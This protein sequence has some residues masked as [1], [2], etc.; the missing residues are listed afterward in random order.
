MFKN[1]IKI[2]IRNLS[3]HKA[4]AG[5]NIFGLAFGLAAFWMIVL[6]IADELSYDR[7]NVNAD[8]IVRVIQHA[9]WG[10]N[11]MHEAPTS[12][13]FAPAMK[14]AFP[15]V[16]EATRILTEGGG[17]INYKDKRLTTDDIF[18]TDSNIFQVFTF[19]FLYGDA[20]TALTAPQSMVITE[21]LAVKLFGDPQKALNETIYFENNYPN[22]TTG[23]IKN[24]PQN[25]HFRF[26]ALRS[27]PQG[28]SGAWQ[29]FDVYTYLL[30]KKG[31][32]IKSLEAKL[33]NFAANS[34]QKL[35]KVDDYKM[36]LQPLT[37]IH[38]HSDLRFEIS[39]NGS[40]N[41]VYLF[42]AIATLI[43][44]IAIINYINLSTA[45]S[46]MRLKE[47]G[48]RKVVGSGK[49]QL[50]AMFITESVLV[51]LLAA[52]IGILMMQI[53]MPLF[54]QL[55][56]K[57]LVIWQFGK[58][59]TLILLAGFT[60]LTG[61]ISGI[62][63]SLFLSRFKTIP[64]LKGQMGNLSAN[65][66]F[67]RSL[68]IFQFVITVVMI[69]ASLV[70]YR[71]LQFARHKDLGFN[72]DQL[73]TFHIDDRKVRNNTSALK[74][75]LLQN[76]VIEGVA[77]AG[78][79]IGN[80][81]LGGL[82]YKLQSESGDF[83]TST[84]MAQELMVDADYVPAMEIKILNGRNFST[85]MPSDQYGS[86]L[87]NETLVKKSGWKNP[88]GK[89]LRFPIDDSTGFG[90]RTVV[91]VVKDFHTYSL[92]HLVEPLVMVMPPVASM[93]DNLYVKIARGRVKEA[94]GYIDK[95]Y[96]SF[97]KTN[98]AEYHFLD[99]NFAKQYSAEEKQGQVALV[100]T[101]L[102]ILIACLGLFG[103]ATFT[104][105]QR[106]KEIGIRKVL[107]ASIMGI[108]SMLSADFLKLVLVAACIALPVA[109]LA[110]SKWLQNFAY[111]INID[112]KPFALAG[113]VAVGIAFITVSFQ[114]IKAAIANPVKSLRTE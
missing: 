9:R 102:A 33:P 96:R 76:P 46:S 47:I 90:E 36:E 2:A 28:Y 48:V 62:Y 37:S 38:L 100:F 51:T 110:M 12:A 4:Y 45:R 41:R 53:T 114:A 40:M 70:V 14:A 109:W 1:Y 21:S 74:E 65:I 111:H 3:Q 60:I 66:L 105:Q 104:A 25:A 43:L 15:E 67:R 20:T 61:I 71:Q 106:T 83:S 64:A 91:G 81:N 52:C 112:W 88:I 23:V 75:Q 98:P 101:L 24:I 69:S 16:Q 107:G 63:P 80:N 31:T 32:T 6:Y 89:K 55:V 94:L 17:I 10:E 5:I 99:A 57:Q 73:L 42:I 86:A 50:A 108:V 11:D 30:L 18:F 113:A 85:T 35:M 26:S 39:P 77:V 54:N 84:T 56:Q 79:P 49:K 22:R 78:N 8:R 95:V 82:G 58:L 44:I 103:L 7:F 59:T 97:D 13:P 93:G 29:N 19:P 72:K 27:L 92:Q 34:I 87:V 68:V